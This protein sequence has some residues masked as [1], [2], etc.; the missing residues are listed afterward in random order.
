MPQ[1]YKNVFIMCQQ[2]CYQ[3]QCDRHAGLV[4]NY[5]T[6]EAHLNTPSNSFWTKMLIVA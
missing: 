3:F 1:L 5:S 6:L 2:M 4:V